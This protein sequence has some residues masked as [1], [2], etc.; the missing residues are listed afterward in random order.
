[1]L[2]GFLG[3]CGACPPFTHDAWSMACSTPVFARAR[4]G[5]REFADDVGGNDLQAAWE[6]C[7]AHALVTGT[8][9]RKGFE[10]A[11]WEI[12]RRHGCPAL[13]VND[14]W[15]NLGGRF[16]AGRP[17]FVGAV[18]AGQLAELAG[19]GFAGESL[20][21]T[22]HPWLS[23]L[24]A[25]RSQLAAATVPPFA[26]HGVR[27]LFAS[28]PIAQGVAAG[29]DPPFGFDEF[30]AFTV[31]H[32]AACAVAQRGTPVTLAAKFHPREEAARFIALARRLPWPEGLTFVPVDRG[33]TALP[34]VLWSQLVAGI[35]S[36]LL[37]EAMIFGRPVVSV[38]P[39]LAREETFI[40]ARRGYATTL[41]DADRAASVLQALLE[42]ASARQQLSRRQAPFAEGIP[43]DSIT[44]L[45]NWIHKH[46]IVSRL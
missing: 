16:A 35:S 45:L 31:L 44:P 11:L 23:H 4:V 18:D 9:L 6:R 34:W 15:M 13:A 27:V 37:L 39:G 29:S 30:D 42:D 12:A 28:E 41:T 25:C 38:Q 5:A 10:T 46:A 3:Q 33:Q 43:A 8:T 24:R 21:V 2:A 1:M 36:M 40:A 20:L 22:G 26:G 7:P 14:S 19:L 32:R 17:D